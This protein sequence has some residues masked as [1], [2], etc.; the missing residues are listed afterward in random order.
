MW[1]LLC[2]EKKIFQK[3]NSDFCL[4]LDSKNSKLIDK[5]KE[6]NEKP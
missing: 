3:K 2:Q 5:I 6:I 4:S 1:P